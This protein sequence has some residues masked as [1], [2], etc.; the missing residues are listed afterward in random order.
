MRMLAGIGA[1]MLFAGA[2]AMGQQVY[3]PPAHAWETRT[4]QQAGFDA[5]K[6]KAAVD[7]ALTVESPTRTD[8]A[9]IA[10]QFAN[11]A[12]Y[13]TIIGPW[14]DQRGGTNGIVIRGG[15]IVAEWGD[16]RK[17]DMT[18][19]ATKSYLSTVAGL[20][21]DAGLIPNLLDPVSRDVAIAEFTND[22]HNARITWHHLLTQTSEWQGTLW[23]RPDWADRFNPNA[24]KRPVREPGSTWTYNDVRVNVLALALLNVW[25]E[26]LPRVLKERVMDPIGASQTWRWYGYKNSWV[27]IDGL[28]MQSVSGGGHWGGGLHISSRDHARFGLLL[29]RNGKWRDRQLLS[30]RWIAMATSPTDVRPGY[31]YLWWLN[32][33]DAIKGAPA[34]AFWAAGNGGNNIYID[35]ENDLV[36]VTRWTR[37]FN[38]IVARVIASIQ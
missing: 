9:S 33:A 8:S 25:R 7:Y 29:L 35:R 22:P 2:P 36:I 6:L 28:R 15:Y 37:D 18:F 31:G 5:A 32:S 12:P 14:V 4:A 24:G 19:S 11:E 3:Y 38:G 10:G 27:E 20:A 1:L 23:D 13:N 26:P 34:S 21:F 16:T 17:V 30:E